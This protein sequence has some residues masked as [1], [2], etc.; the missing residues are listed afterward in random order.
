VH[1]NARS[2]AHYEVLEEAPLELETEFRIRPQ[3]VN[4]TKHTLFV[5]S[6]MTEEWNEAPSQE[7]ARSYCLVLGFNDELII[8]LHRCGV[9]V[10]R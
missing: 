7:G 2:A 9:F 1:R 10:E 4:R 6:P 3:V 5:C 8:D